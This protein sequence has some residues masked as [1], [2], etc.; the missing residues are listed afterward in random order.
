MKCIVEASRLQPVQRSKHDS[1]HFARL[2]DNCFPG[3]QPGEDQELLSQ[4]QALWREN[5]QSYL[6]ISTSSPA[7]LPLENVSVF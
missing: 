4:I 2:K 6:N 5:P 7:T 3:K 1:T